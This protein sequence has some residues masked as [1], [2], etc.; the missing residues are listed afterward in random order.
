MSVDHQQC[1]LRAIGNDSVLMSSESP[2]SNY[3]TI[4]PTS[5]SLEQLRDFMTMPGAPKIPV[6]RSSHLPAR[7]V[8]QYKPTHDDLLNS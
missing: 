3:N 1:L 6:L 7:T 8:P 4:S 5:T 2:T